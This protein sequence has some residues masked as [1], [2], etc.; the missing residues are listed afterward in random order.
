MTDPRNWDKELADIDKLM[1]AR[2]AA[3]PVASGRVA[4]PRALER[5]VDRPEDDARLDYRRGPAILA[6]VGAHR[7]PPGPGANRTTVPCSS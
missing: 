5:P 6:A 1:G 7:A 2:T 3:R 4:A